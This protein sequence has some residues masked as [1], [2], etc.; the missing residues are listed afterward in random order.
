MT[1]ARALA[2]AQALRDVT[3][4][5]A[6]AVVGVTVVAVYVAQHRHAPTLPECSIM[7]PETQIRGSEEQRT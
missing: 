3:L 6:V 5:V 4:A 7:L 2:A 1:A